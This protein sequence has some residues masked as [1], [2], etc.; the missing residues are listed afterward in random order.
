MLLLVGRHGEILDRQRNIQALAQF[1]HE[2]LV[3]HRLLSAQVEIAV[4]RFARTAQFEQ[5][6]QQSHRVG[7]A[8]QCHKHGRKCG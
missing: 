4:C 6:T 1:P 8:A 2:A 5:H 7:A 3:A